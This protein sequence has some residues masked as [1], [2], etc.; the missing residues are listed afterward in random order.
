[1]QR[2][3]QIVLV[4]VVTLWAGLV[5]FG[6][7]TDYGS[8]FAFVQHVLA[9]DSIFPDSRIGYRAIHAPWLQH[10][11]YLGI[12]ACECAVALLC[13]FGAARM[14]RARQA[15]ASGYRR[16]KEL[17]I[18]GLGLGV[19][20]WLGGFM[21]IGGEWFGM[22]MSSQ[23]NGIASAFRFASVQLGLLIYL[24]LPEQPGGA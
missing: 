10:T 5:A 22:W 8:N 23:W 9:M 17:A 7:L 2:V 4:A 15:P 6:N 1:M 14:W 13:G 19:V 16:S 24:S 12:I 3:V 20:L 11:A 18:G 21:V